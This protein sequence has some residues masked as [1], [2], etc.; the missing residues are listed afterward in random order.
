STNGDPVAGV[1]TLQQHATKAAAQVLALIQRFETLKTHAEGLSHWRDVLKQADSLF[2]ASGL[3]A[4]LR[5][6]L[7]KVI[8][9]SISEFLTKHSFDGLKNWEVFQQKLEL[10]N[11]QFSERQTAGNQQFGQLKDEYIKVLR[12]I[13][14]KQPVMRARY[15]Y[16]ADDESYNDLFLEIK[17]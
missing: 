9:P 7:T 2:G 10:L 6:Q 16:G 17:E 1:L 14:V 3:P 15:E 12:E 11:R 5:D 13:N 8:V 4:D